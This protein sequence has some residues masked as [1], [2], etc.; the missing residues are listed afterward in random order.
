MRPKQN[1]IQDDLDEMVLFAFDHYAIPFQ[2]GV[3]VGINDFGQ[4]VEEET[5]RVLGLGEPGSPLKGYAAADCI[6]PGESGFRQ[7]VVWQDRD[8]IVADYPIRIRIRIDFGGI[9]PEDL[10]LYAVYLYHDGD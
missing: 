10:R 1:G 4:F 5:N 2:K 6:A 9:R 3:K 7:A 8:S